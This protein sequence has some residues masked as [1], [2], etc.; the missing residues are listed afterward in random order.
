MFWYLYG[1][2][3]CDEENRYDTY[4]AKTELSYYKSA[5]I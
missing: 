2:G 3:T 1:N 5:L 4:I